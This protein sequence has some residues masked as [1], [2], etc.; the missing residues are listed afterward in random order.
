M[1]GRS[2]EGILSGQ[3]GLSKSKVADEFGGGDGGGGGSRIGRQNGKE[4]QAGFFESVFFQIGL[5]SMSDSK[6]NF[7]GS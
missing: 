2:K 1:V 5:K 6:I 4:L 7:I 3:N